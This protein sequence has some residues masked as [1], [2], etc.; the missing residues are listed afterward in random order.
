MTREYS[1]EDD[2][3]SSTSES[4][5]IGDSDDDDSVLGYC[6]YDESD[7]IPIA[8][9]TLREESVGLGSSTNRK[10]PRVM[11]AKSN[12]RPLVGHQPTFMLVERDKIVN[13]IN[14]SFAISQVRIQCVGQ[15][16]SKIKMKKLIKSELGFT[17]GDSAD[18]VPKFI[19]IRPKRS[20]SCT[21]RVYSSGKLVVKDAC[22]RGSALDALE[23]LTKRVNELKIVD[24]QLTQFKVTDARFDTKTA[25]VYDL[26]KL[27]SILKTELDDE[28]II[29]FNADDPSQGVGVR[30]HGHANVYIRMHR[31]GNISA[32]GNIDK[33]SAWRMISRVEMLGRDAIVCV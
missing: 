10:I 21:V 3:G 11:V 4:N 9:D 18:R 6:E 25:G 24:T 5:Y 1:R 8:M 26:T 15:W 23:Y 31:R 7:A 2:A 20:V 30:F 12:A 13:G 16:S 17:I 29:Y 33:D 32:Q 28:A 22:D 14:R 27:A 19:S